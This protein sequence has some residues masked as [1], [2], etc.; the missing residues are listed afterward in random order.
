MR[1]EAEAGARLNLADH[2][3]AVPLL[4]A[5]RIVNDSPGTLRELALRLDA[6][7]AFLQPRTWR[8][9]TVAAGQRLELAGLDLEIDGALLARLTAAEPARLVWRLLQGG[10]SGRAPH[11]AA[12]TRE[13]A[14]AAGAGAA[15]P[16]AAPAD[17]EELARHALPLELL[18]RDH[19]GGLAGMPEMVAAFVQPGEPAVERLLKEA[20]GL[21]R[22]HERDAAL[23]GYRGGPARAWELASAVWSAV[24][25]LGI[26]LMLLP[27]GFE[28]A[29]QKVRGPQQLADTRLATGLDL[30][31]LFCAALEQCG[32]NPLLVFTQGRALAGVWLRPEQFAAA[33]VD[34]VTALRKR[35]RLRE[36][37]L[38]DPELATQRPCPPFSRALERGAQLVAEAQDAAFELA[39]DIRRARLQRVRPLAGTA[40]PPPPD[41][42]QDPAALAPAF[43]PAPELPAVPQEAE[44]VAP[45]ED[46]LLRWQ[47]KLLDLSLRNK[48]LNFRDGRKALRLEAPDPA[49]LEDLL[50]QG[51]ALKLL[52]RPALMDAAAGDP[53][54]AA[55]HEART[56]EEPRRALALDALA[57]R[58]VFVG[59][60]GEELEARLVELYRSAR[61][62]LQEGGTNTLFL[63]LGF[64]CWTRD[65]RDDKR[66]RAPLILVPVTLDR[67][68]VR[69]GFTL[70][71]LDDEPR[72]NPTLLEML[73]Q[74]FRLQLGVGEGALPK[75][76]RG[77]DV[78]GVWRAVSAAV[79]DVKGWEVVEDVVLSTFSFAKHL[80]WHD[81]TE[82][83]AQLREN[84]VVRHLIDTPREPYPGGGAFPDARRLDADC[85]PERT[86]CPLPADS[87]Q[88]SAV[89]AASAGRDFV[90]IGPPGTGK[91]QTIANLIAQC[92]AEGRRV[93]FVSEKIAALD[94]VH[95]RL[96]DA[97]LGDFCL[98]LHS[99]KAR[100]NE[101]L[102]Q[103]RRSWEAG[104]RADAEGW[105]AEARRLMALRGRLN[106][107]VER[108]HHRHA[109][110]L[111]AFDAIG[112]REAG[113]E[114]PPLGLSWPSP[115]QHDAEALEALRALAE[116][117]DADAQAL[118]GAP[119]EH[120]LA[121]VRHADWS[122]SW[123]QALLDAAQQLV[124]GAQRLEAAAHALCGALALPQ[125]PLHRRGRHALAL[126]A[127]LLPHAAGRDWRFALRPDARR[128]CTELEAGRGLLVRHGEL[129][130]RLP[131]PWPAATLDALRRAEQLVARRHA[132]RAGLPRPWPAKVCDALAKGL[133]LL[134]S[135]G[136]LGRELSVSYAAELAQLDVLR[137]QRDWQQAVQ[138][139]WPLGWLRQ[140]RIRARLLALVQ[141]VGEPDVA[142]DLPRLASMRL[143]SRQLDALG[144]LVAPAGELWRG[145]QTRAD[146][147]RAALALQGALLA[148][149]EGLPWD[150]AGL[151]PVA[152]GRCGAALA[153]AL[154]GLRELR[155]I[156]AELA[157]LE[158][159][160][161]SG[162]AGLWAGRDTPPE[163]LDV[164][165]AFQAALAAATAGAPW[166][167]EGLEPLERGGF[168]AAMAADLQCMR[169]LRGLQRQIEAL[170][171]LGAQTGG[172]WAGLAG[173]PQELERALKF[174]AALSA[175]LAQL[176]ATPGELAAL[177]APLERLLGEDKELLQASGAIAAAARDY[178]EAYGVLQQAQERLD[179]A[180]ATPAEER[181]ALGELPPAALAA[182]GQALLAARGR[183]RDW[184]AWRKAR[185]E[186]LALGLGPLVA[187][188]EQ[189]RVAPGTA[190]EL[191]EADYCRWWLDAVVD[192]D[193]VLRGFVSAEHER[194]IAE[195]RALDE[196]FAALTRD[197]L[198]ASLCAGRPALE[199][200]ARTS[201]WGVLRHEMQKKARH[202][203]L[204][205]LLARIPDALTRL[206]PCLLMS[207]LSVAQY[208]SP[209][210]ASFDL[211]VFDEA[212]QIP[213][214]DA[215]GAIARGRQVVMVGDPKQLPPTSFF[216]RA[217]AEPGDEEPEAD[218]ESILDE[219][220]GANLPTLN[221]R[222]HYRSRSE[223][224]IAFSNHRYY[225]G[226]LVTF[227]SPATEDRAVAF[228]VVEDGVYEKGGA[229]TNPAEARALVADLLARL[230]SP[231][232]REAGL[233]VG[234]V[235]FNAEQQGLIEDLLDD[236]R[237]RD[238]AL[239]PFFD[240]AALEPVFVKNLESVQ[241]DERDLMYFSVTYGPGRDGALSMNF[242]P[243]N[244]QGGERRLNV[245]I[246][247]ARR[248][249][250]VFSSL[251]PEQMDLS[252]T[253]AQ[254]VRDLKH[255]LEFAERGPRALG[256]AVHGSVGGF[257][258]PFEQAVAAALAAH[259][260]RVQPQVGV[261]AFRIDLGVVDPDAPGRYLAGIECDGATYHRSATARDRDKLREQVLRGLGWEIVRIWSTDWWVDRDGTLEKVLAR[262]DALR[263]ERRRHVAAAAALAAGAQ[264]AAAAPLRVEAEG[265][266]AAGQ[267]L[268]EM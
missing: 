99:S 61:T 218:L 28:H 134:G 17:G 220:L 189:G 86:F 145:L 163:R 255:F 184:C 207:P 157:R 239:E 133:E 231:G 216:D 88:L 22:R 113:R 19:W 73:R 238:P 120:P 74:D 208:L 127:K 154:A 112:R 237:R 213:V 146:E 26:D 150:E 233:T 44:G 36:L 72:F 137:L 185:A 116:R 211:V 121:A 188:I 262:L 251:R 105:R 18:P 176:A 229:R 174:A 16:D 245:A 225:G 2:L 78:A 56:Q 130:A 21:L 131:A 10:A 4:R 203:P 46:R 32:L 35:L 67:K 64:L 200:V 206:T 80:M 66:H 24:G 52:P 20:A 248:E 209:E 148:A 230:R 41:A 264:D 165:L 8:I 6:E 100:K 29:G 156:D 166:R 103:L 254:G 27:A 96:R 240:E 144:T 43:E 234:V 217:E 205:E 173:R 153:Q 11:G 223:S 108:L 142:A 256:E 104:G 177:K 59:L 258:S 180:L 138:S 170:E 95:R 158:P 109:N 54:S 30:S 39:V 115:Q 265:G 268:P 87:S 101:V 129:R 50:A 3:N 71:L 187:A 246:T 192:G 14:V 1:I 38:F 222:W 175:A 62:A 12:E 249:L 40:A 190:R 143:A 92:L 168:P 82:R 214:W 81:L 228:R 117:L 186:A 159:Q 257:D 267:E 253:Q 65:A 7:P 9:D 160:L 178:L 33:V 75:D 152:Q 42:A 91:S 261:S 140:R 266:A 34:D 102:A 226:A 247:R 118:G 244:R 197:W 89:M 149:C 107:Y 69:S 182:R 161:Q 45:P 171:P 183:L 139:P 151:E 167:D 83:I 195:F 94:V 23:D 162:S 25:A 202:L 132:L 53:R 85:P 122:P 15:T 106:R 97:G 5:L 126:L 79:K 179:A 111:S 194:R 57:R 199:G 263:D 119:S 68:S 63:A 193:E 77:L 243:L 123:Q 235:T 31:L 242:G 221:L 128:L 141:G 210:A 164:A 48:L 201:E 49:R 198:H 124:Q 155:G 93:L 236:A 135:H 252:R 191:F 125:P 37:V 110:G 55:L 224:L 227:P 196:R 204:R 232:F 212:S 215:I 147:L 219:C 13:T 60:P 181:G 114:L 98:E 250:R 172:T 260:W 84:P 241:G 58:E 70:Q 47:R 259:G 136:E 90:L 169:E 76:E 51:Q